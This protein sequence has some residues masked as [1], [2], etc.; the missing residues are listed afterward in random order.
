[1]SDQLF[2]KEGTSSG[3]KETGGFGRSLHS[4][5][6]QL[7]EAI[8]S[9]LG[10]EA[11][12]FLA[13]PVADHG[14]RQIDWYA[15]VDGDAVPFQE[16]PADQQALLGPLVGQRLDQLGGLA[17]QLAENADPVRAQLGLLLKG[18]LAPPLPE[19]VFFISNRIPVVTSWG[20]TQEH[21][22]SEQVDLVGRWWPA[23]QPPSGPGKHMDPPPPPVLDP[24]PSPPAHPPKPPPEPEPATVPAEQFGPMSIVRDI[25]QNFEER[26]FSQSLR[27]IGGWIIHGIGAAATL[28]FLVLLTGRAVGVVPTRTVVASEP[29]LTA[30]ASARAEEVLLRQRLDTLRTSII[31]KQIACT[32]KTRTSEPSPNAASGERR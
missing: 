16:L 3:L 8:E 20:F 18:V 9:Y 21:G 30:L 6:P 28:T 10:A 17:D 24:S 15:S 19:D 25:A 22:Y 11:A 23:A 27:F 31:G 26:N 32:M 13:E 2:L 4:L 7:R 14:R 1:M 29:N 12:L 5:Y